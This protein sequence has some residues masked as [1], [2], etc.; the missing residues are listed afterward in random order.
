MLSAGLAFITALPS[1]VGGVTSFLTAYQ[2]AKVRMLVARTGMTRDVAIQ[3]LQSAVTERVSVN[4]IIAGSFILQ[5]LIV[6]FALPV[7]AYEWKV[8]IYDNVLQWG[9]TPAIRG[10]VAAWMGTIVNWL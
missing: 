5:C 7:V 9:S 1:L 10:E 4:N 8:V 6:G 3:T 2:D